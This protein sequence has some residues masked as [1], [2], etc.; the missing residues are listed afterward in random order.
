MPNKSRTQAVNKDAGKMRYTGYQVDKDGTE[1]VS[2]RDSA[3]REWLTNQKTGETEMSKASREVT[4]A[5]APAGAVVRAKR[6]FPDQD[7]A[8]S[9]DEGYRG[10]K[11]R[12]TKPDFPDQNLA[13]SPDEGY[14]GEKKMA[15]GGLVKSSASRRADGAAKKG[16]TKGRTL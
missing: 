15:K 7:F 10:E 13:P 12:G 11:K 16:K 1:W 14:R 3:N 2:Q 9:P 8:P 4:A 6:D 5:R